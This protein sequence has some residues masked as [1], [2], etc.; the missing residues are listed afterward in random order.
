MVLVLFKTP[1]TPDAKVIVA[2]I[3]VVLIAAATG[4]KVL[5]PRVLRRI[6]LVLSRAPVVACNSLVF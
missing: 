6:R 5:V 1:R 4:S 3:V 2:L